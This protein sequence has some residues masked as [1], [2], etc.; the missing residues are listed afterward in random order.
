MQ[1]IRYLADQVV[2]LDICKHCLGA[3]FLSIQST[4]ETS[5]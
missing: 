1:E 3:V 4:V 2:L 5:V